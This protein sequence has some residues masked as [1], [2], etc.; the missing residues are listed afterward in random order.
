MPRVG[1]DLGSGAGTRHLSHQ[2]HLLVPRG[3][4]MEF[5]RRQTKDISYDNKAEAQGAHWRKW[6]PVSAKE[7]S[8]NGKYT[9]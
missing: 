5:H 3:A 7:G 1:G 2:I 4:R 9:R 8:I 6:K